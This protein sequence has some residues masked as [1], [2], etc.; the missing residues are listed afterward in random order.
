MTQPTPEV[1]KRYKAHAVKRVTL[2]L[3]RNTDADI[4]EKLEQVP[5]KQGYIKRCIREDIRKDE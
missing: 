1:R 3:N 5:S 2:D 4:L